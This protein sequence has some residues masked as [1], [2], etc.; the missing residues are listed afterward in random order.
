MPFLD[1]AILGINFF[2]A[3]VNSIPYHE[4]PK[5]LILCYIN[6]V[7][8]KCGIDNSVFKKCGINNSVFKKCGIDNSVF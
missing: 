2:S 7:F 4:W 6:S 1:E 8:Q 5:E 3:L